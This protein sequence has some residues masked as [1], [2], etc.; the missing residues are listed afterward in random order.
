MWITLSLVPAGI[1]NAAGSLD[2]VSVAL[3]D[4][5]PNAASTSVSYTFTASGVDGGTAVK[6]VKVVWSTTSSG[7]QAP[8][9]FSGAS[10]S[11]DASSSTIINSSATGW[12]LAKSDGTSSSGQNNIYKYTNSTGVTP[13]T[14]SGATFVITGITNPTTSNSTYFFSFNT[15]GNTD[16]ATSPI[17]N[18]QPEFIITDGST[19]SLTVDP[20]L[21]FSINSIGSGQGCDGTTTT[22]GSTATTIPFGNVTPASNAVVCQD[23]Q[24]ATNASNGYTIYLR[25]TGAPSNGLNQIAD[26]SGSNASPAAFSAA[27]TEAYGYTTDDA[28]LGTGT[29]NRFTSPSQAWAAATTSNAEIGY[30]AGPVTNTH[31]KIGHQVGVSTITNPGTYTTT[32]IYTCTPIY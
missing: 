20:T 30:E 18:T 28:T 31:Y 26:A 8:T 4:P 5:R 9:G 24:A 19:L 3:S 10:G 12:S 16:C 17:D 25:Y 6:C 13:G 11:V 23:L 7:T 27:G 1:L 21:A 22:A 14:T 2:H 32:I 15:Y 29:A